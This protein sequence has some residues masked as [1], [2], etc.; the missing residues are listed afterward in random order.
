M[1]LSA[2]HQ[3]SR[4]LSVALL[5]SAGC[6]VSGLARGPVTPITTR[7]DLVTCAQAPAIAG[8]ALMHLGYGVAT[9]TLPRPGIAGAVVGER[10]DGW[11]AAAPE[12][13]RRY[14]VAIS[15]TCDD[16][17]TQFVIAG[18]ETGSGRLAL[19]RSFASAIATAAAQRTLSRA[20]E[21]RPGLVVTVTPVT[22]VTAAE[23]F[24][25]ALAAA[26]LTPIWVEIANRSP[27]GYRFTLARVALVSIEG[28]RATPLTAA[29]AAAAVAAGGG[30]ATA[31]ATITAAGLDDGEIPPGATRT[32]YLF[33]PAATYRRASLV[34]VE[35]DSE[36]TEGV[37]VDF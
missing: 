18:E 10:V 17:G 35:L 36:E 20:P 7:V 34:F 27:R 26:D 4:A 2:C 19:G 16:Q 14:Q 15:I 5:A 23:P 37:R 30:A 1:R 32:G 33:A 8:R 24:P 31:Q 28:T 9:S 21:A 12:A 13:G 22:A 6:A 11:T 29:A 3:T 25:T